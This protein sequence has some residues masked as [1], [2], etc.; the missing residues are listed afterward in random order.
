M[1]RNTIALLAIILATAATPARARAADSPGKT[2]PQAEIQI[3]V[4]APADQ[5]VRALD[6]HPGGAPI[7]V[8]LFDDASLTLFGRGLRLRL[9]VA[10]DHS[11]LTLKAADQDCARLDPELVPTG[12]GKCE[13]DIYANSSAGAVSLNLSLGAKRTNDLLSGRVTPGQVLSPSQVRY[14]RDIVAIWPLPPG[15]RRLGPMQVRTYHTKGKR[16][17]IDI[18]QLPHGE[19]YA[20]ISRKVPLA[21]ATRAMQVMEADLS[22]AGVEMCSDQS[23]QAVNKLRALLRQ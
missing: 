6:L 15:I 1:T 14:L 18:T 13:Y 7:E 12:E 8:W 22:R 21:E 11:Q 20:E 4:C 10:N 2:R 9:R 5:I 16:Y 3:A 19:R 17:D 23:S